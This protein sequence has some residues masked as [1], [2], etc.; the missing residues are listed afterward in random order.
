M[1]VRCDRETDC[2]STNGLVAPA[3]AGD[4][5]D[6]D[7][8]R[9]IGLHSLHGVGRDCRPDGLAELTN[10]RSDLSMQLRIAH[11]RWNNL[12]TLAL[13][14]WGLGVGV[15]TMQAQPIALPGATAA[16]GGALHLPAGLTLT[17]LASKGASRV[18]TAHRMRAFL[19]AIATQAF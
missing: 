1:K 17:C 8:N 3:I 13:I 9:S 6:P 4:G 10:C 15:Q 18:I 19:L 11:L 7:T 2:T 12:L 5:A 14:E 16:V